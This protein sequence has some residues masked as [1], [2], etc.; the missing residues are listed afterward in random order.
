MTALFGAALF[1]QRV[2]LSLAP[3]SSIQFG[4]VVVCAMA[5]FARWLRTEDDRAL[6]GC[7]AVLAVAGTI[8]YEG[9]LF[10]GA[11][12]AAYWLSGNRNPRRFAALA[13]IVLT[14]PLLTTA[15]KALTGG[16]PVAAVQATRYSIAEILWRNPLAQFTVANASCLN[17]LGLLGVWRAGR[18]HAKFLAVAFGPLAAIGAALLMLL[19][20]QTGP[21]W[22]MTAVW[23]L[24]LLP[25][26]ARYVARGTRF[27]IAA[28]LLMVLTFGWDLHRIAQVSEWAF[29][30]YDR[31]A[32]AYLQAE[33]ASRPS[34]KVQ[35]ESSDFFY[36]NVLTA[37][38]TP[39]AF[40]PAPEPRF[41][42]SAVAYWLFR[43]PEAL[44]ELNGWANAEK[45]KEFGPWSLY[46]RPPAPEAP[47][48]NE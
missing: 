1:S 40:E 18:M 36:L 29:P 35:V 22:R 10:A 2:A 11:V 6:L 16:N 19:S 8:R 15:Y 21:S 39:D 27:P 12:L 38:Q 28:G 30:A 48:P 34:A 44:A 9:W 14:F 45:V 13:A 3:L 42:N 4:L 7:A 24:L 33:L 26:T 32:G 17:L 20:A 43:T 31:A 5:L 41:E 46:R 37:S 47:R 23:G 25:F